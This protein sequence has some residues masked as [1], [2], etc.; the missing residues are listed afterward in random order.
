MGAYRNLPELELKY[1]SG[2][3]KKI[4]ISST[5]DGANM[6]R[7][8]F[9]EDTIEYREEFIVLYLNSAN[10]TVGWMKHST[11]GTVQTVVDVKMVLTTGLLCGA[12]AII[13][14]HN[15]PS[16]QMYPSQEDENITK[17]L[18]NGCNAIDIKLLDHFILSGENKSYYSFAN[19]GKI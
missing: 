13:V 7:Q 9:N 16:G 4:K 1:K 18:K 17:R 11:G 19:E 15:H 8:L 2:T 12:S 14:A 5:D 10:K 3:V 6:F